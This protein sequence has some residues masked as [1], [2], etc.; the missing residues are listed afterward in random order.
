VGAAYAVEELDQEL[1]PWCIV[2]GSAAERYEAEFT[3]VD[4]KVPFE[5]R[6]AVETRTPGFTRWQDERWLVH[7]GDAAVFLGLAVRVNWRHARR[8]V[9][10][11]T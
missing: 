8:D 1:C 2:D 10:E 6:R 5:V 4:G 9:T 3:Q 7:C 11:V